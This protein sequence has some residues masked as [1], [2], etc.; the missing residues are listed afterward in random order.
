MPLSPH[1]PC[2]HAP[3]HH[4]CHLAVPLSPHMPCCHVPHNCTHHLTVP[5]TAT[6]AAHLT[7]TM[8]MTT[9]TTP[10]QQEYCNHPHHNYHSVTILPPF[11]HFLTHMPSVSH[12]TYLH[13]PS[14]HRTY[15]CLHHTYMHYPIHPCP[16][17]VPYGCAKASYH[18][19]L[20]HLSLF[21]IASPFGMLLDLYPHSRY[22]TFH[23][24]Q[25]P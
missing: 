12:A 10:K 20:T 17:L 18:L 24:H 9:A 25:K 2:Y 5:V 11:F 1:A 19:P 22:I 15:P 6:H 23:L 16:Y 3:H 4:T 14:N 7:T 8:A 13:V 21:S